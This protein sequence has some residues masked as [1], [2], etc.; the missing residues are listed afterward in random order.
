[1]TEVRLNGVEKA[2]GD[3]KVLHDIKLDIQNREFVV[4]G[5]IYLIGE[6]RKR[7]REKFGAPPPASAPLY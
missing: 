2:Y 6:V 5:S 1:M 7:L 3:V 4:C